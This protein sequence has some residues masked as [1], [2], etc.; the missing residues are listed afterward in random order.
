MDMQRHWWRVIA[1]LLLIV[2][3]IL[4]T[5]AQFQLITFDESWLGMVGL[6]VGAVIFLSLWLSNTREWWPLIPGL[7]MLSWAV[8]GLLGI[9]GLADWLVNLI[10]FAGSALP[11]LYVFS[12]NRKANWWALIPG[13]IFGLMG[14]ATVLGGLLGEGWTEFLVLLGIALAFLVVFLVNRRNWWAL[15]PAGILTVVAFSAGP[16]G[17]YA[18]VVWASGLVL[19][20]A[21]MILYALLRRS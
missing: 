3:G 17:S 19:A 4:L 11:F 5:L 10:G 21:A 9:L 20:G 6:F 13:G 12:R 18:Q 14:V 1:G 7:I 16:W 15:I 2:V 8:S